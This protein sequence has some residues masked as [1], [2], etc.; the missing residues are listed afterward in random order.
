MACLSLRVVALV[1]ATTLGGGGAL[2][3]VRAEPG[4]AAR[5]LDACKRA[6]FRLVIDVGHTADAPGARSARG[7]SEFV[8]N[9]A[10]A[11]RIEDHLDAAGFRRT[12]LLITDGPARKGLAERVR[13]ANALGADLLLSIHHDSVPDRFLE[14]WEFEGEERS[15]SDR[16]RGHSIFVSHDNSDRAGSLLFARLLGNRLRDRGLQYTPHYTDRIMGNRQRLLVDAQAGVYRYDQLIVLRNTGMPAVLLEAGSIIN[17]DEELLAGSVERQTLI[18]AAVT[19]AVEAFCAAR[20][21]RAPTTA[22]SGPSDVSR[23][24][25]AP[26]AAV[27]PSRMVKQR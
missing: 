18:S 10:L 26:A 22:A 19:D 12:V 21:P 15:F 2:L 5:P 7:I 16:F 17:R 14:K 9:L 11:K 13:R 27:A 4:I 3:T 23:Q 24:T 8:F 25:A 6:A 1:V 20:R